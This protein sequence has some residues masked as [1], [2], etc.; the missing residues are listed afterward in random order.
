MHGATVLF[1][2][3]IRFIPSRYYAKQNSE[4]KMPIAVHI[5]DIDL[6]SNIEKVPRGY[7]VFCLCYRHQTVDK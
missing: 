7:F 6:D 2:C 1:Q 3:I 5:R 4:R